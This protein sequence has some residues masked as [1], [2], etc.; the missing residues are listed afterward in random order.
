MFPK[1]TS[2][3]FDLPVLISEP[4]LSEG[5]DMVAILEE[6]GWTAVSEDGS[7][8][9]QFEHTILITSDGCEILTLPEKEFENAI[10]VKTT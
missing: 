9:A 10:M 8:S 3:T 4:I 1:K 6:D 5:T 7:R 2:L